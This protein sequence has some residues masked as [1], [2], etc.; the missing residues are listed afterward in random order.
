MFILVVNLFEFCQFVFSYGVVMDG[1][2]V[3]DLYGN[4]VMWE[5]FVYCW[6][7][8]VGEKMLLDVLE[9]FIDFLMF[10]VVMV[11]VGKVDVCIVGN[12]FFTVNVL[13]VGLCIIGLQ[14]G[15]KMFFFI[16]LMLL[17][18]SG[19]VLGFVDCSVVLQLMVVQLVDIVFVSVEIWC[20]II[21]EELCVVM[22][23]FF[24]NGSV[25]YFCVVNVQQVIEIVCE[26]VL[27]LV[28]DGELQFDVVFV[29]EV[30]V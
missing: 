7:V 8:C 23:L 15:C 9:K 22:L 3:I 17:Q 1:L 12:F 25:C 21:G 29:L 26:C 20:V 27:K 16:F 24:S 19:S 18:Y 5:E 10:V 2:Q 6:L 30:V 4:F 14:L 11:S 13:C 28:V